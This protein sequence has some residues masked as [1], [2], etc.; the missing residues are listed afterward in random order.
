MSATTTLWRPLERRRT[1]VFLAA[2]VLLLGYAVSKAIYTFTDVT[3]VG[4]F[5]VTFGGI[6]LLVAMLGLF[7]L[8]PR[9]REGA[10]WTAL[11]GV[12]VTAV[13][14]VGTLALVGWVAIETLL[15]AGYPAI[16]AESPAWTV[17]VFFGVFVALILGFLL[18]G[19]ASLRSGALSQRVGG[20]LVVPGLSWAGLIVGNVVLTPGQYIGLVYVPIALALLA[21]GYLLGAESVQ[22]DHVESASDPVA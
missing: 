15:N 10:R 13:G 18:F 2:G 7:A 3:P 4:A 20:L 11:A 22:S 17:P 6:G 8:Y 1:T 5:D 19:A 12:L 16:P 9:V 14:A 21:I